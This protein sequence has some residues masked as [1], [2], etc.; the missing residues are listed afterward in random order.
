MQ[1]HPLEPAAALA[2]RLL[3]SLI[4]FHEAWAKISDYSLTVV[5]MQAF[6][7]P[8]ELLPFT[9]ALE[10]GCALLILIGYQ[11]QIA[12]TLLASFCVATAV[13]FHARLGDR[14]QLLHFEKDLA[15]AGGFLVLFARGAGAW[16]LD[17][18]RPRRDRR[19]SA[20]MGI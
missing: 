10:L 20:Q 12:A 1:T 13:L 2:G 8:A 7:I 4:F 17:A 15:I 11:T 18:L 3:L 16:S 14:N 9:V 6:G 5:Y 19:P